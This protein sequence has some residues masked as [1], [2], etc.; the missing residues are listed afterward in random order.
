ME[1]FAGFW[2][3]VVAYLIDTILL[4]VVSGIIGGFV[5][6]GFGSMFDPVAVEQQMLGTGYWLFQLFSML[7]GIAYFAGMESSSWQAT[8]GKKALGLIVVGE[9]GGRISLLRA[10]GRY[11]G[12]I[13]SSLI[14]LIGFIMVA[15]TARKQGLHDM[16]ASTYVVKGQPGMGS[17]A[18]VFE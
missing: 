14:L 5:G 10:I 11:L 7:V 13:L 16:L 9:D 17:R 1:N 2:I 4:A 8:L 3:R 18:S 12:K 15:F 6:F